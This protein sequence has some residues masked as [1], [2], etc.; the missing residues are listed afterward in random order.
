MT[1]S[2]SAGIS[3]GEATTELLADLVDAAAVEVRVGPCK[4]HVLEDAALRLG[5]VRQADAL[6]ARAVDDEH[7]AGLDVADVLGADEVERD[8]LARD[9][10]RVL[11]ARGQDAEAERTDAARIADR[12]DRVRRQ[13]EQRVGALDPRE[14]VDDAVLD[15]DLLAA[16]DQVD[17]HLGVGGRREDRALLLELGAEL[18]GVREV[19]VVADRERA[20]RVVDR[21]RLGVADVRAAGRR[22]ADVADGD[23]T[24]QLLELRRAER[25][26]HEAHRAMREE[27][28]RRR[29]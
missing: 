24:G 3:R 9:D 15:R 13:E 21:E 22:V 19:A 7:L 20:A 28:P 29:S 16:R 17:E 27:P 18:V 12:D 25:V 14:R 26:L 8:G 11:A 2:A 4:V 5:Q 23:A 6:H 1:T 10:V